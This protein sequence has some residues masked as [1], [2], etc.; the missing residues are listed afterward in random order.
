MIPKRITEPTWFRNRTNTTLTS[1]RTIV[2]SVV[3]KKVAADLLHARGAT[4]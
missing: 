2:P 1:S 4:L 3:A